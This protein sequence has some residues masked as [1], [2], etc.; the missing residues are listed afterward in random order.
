MAGLITPSHNPITIYCLRDVASPTGHGPAKCLRIL[1]SLRAA[2]SARPTVSNPMQRAV[3]T[4]LS[5][6]EWTPSTGVM[7]YGVWTMEYNYL[8]QADSGLCFRL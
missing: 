6:P 5:E 1:A 3:P 8:T 4:G 2:G 7:D